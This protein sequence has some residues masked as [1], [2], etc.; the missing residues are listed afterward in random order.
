MAA[1]ITKDATNHVWNFIDTFTSNTYQVVFDTQNKFLDAKIKAS[2]TVTNGAITPTFDEAH[3]GL[4]SYFTNNGTASSYNI[5]IKPQATNTAGFIPLHNSSN[6]VNGQTTY[7]KI[8]TG[9]GTGDSANVVLYTTDGSKAGENISA[10]V[11]AVQ[12]SEP[13]VAGSYYLAFTGSGNSKINKD[14][15]LTSGTIL[16]PGSKTRYFSIQAAAITASCTNATATTTVSPGTVSI[17]KNGTTSVSGKTQILTTIDPTLATSDISKYFIAI[18]ASA[19]ANST[20]TTSSIT[21]TNTA[22]VST[23]GYAPTTLTGAGAISGTATAKTSKRDSGVYYIPVPTAGYSGNSASAEI[24]KTTTDNAS[25]DGINV[26]AILGERTNAEPTSGYYISLQASGSGSSKITTA[27]WLPADQTLTS[28]STT[29]ERF[30]PVTAAVIAVSKTGGS[31]TPT[32]TLSKSNSVTWS[33]SDT[34][35]VWLQATGNGSVSNLSIKANVSTAGYIPTG[36]VATANSLSISAAATPATDKKYI[37]GVTIASGKSFA[38][39]NS[40]TTT[41]TAG[42]SGSTTY[43]I[44]N[45]VAYPSS[46]TTAE[47]SKKIVDG[48]RWVTETVGA[49]SS[50]FATKYGKTIVK[51][52]AASSNHTISNTTYITTSGASSSSY[53]LYI[54]PRHTIGTA[55]YL[56]AASNVEGTKVYYKV[57]RTSVSQNNTTVNSTDSSG[58]PTDVTRGEASWGDGWVAGS[59]IIPATFKNAPTSGVTYIDISKTEEAPILTVLDNNG[60]GYLYINKGYVDNLKISLARLIPD[61]LDGN[62]INFAPANYILTGYAAFDASGVQITGTMQTYTGA[63][64]VTTP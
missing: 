45:V 51:Y 3:S 64:T 31:I 53:D 50:T 38:V 11:T 6:P 43:G 55:G 25:T 2:L 29:A 58:N 8:I 34:S 7:Y 42:I 23:A 59:N 35:G 26:G 47:A 14:G 33:T 36:D 15:W 22:S 17:T 57:K 4:L 39:A 12:D 52:G 46:G 1:S 56:A 49:G 5:Y 21:G 19:A 27:G 44:I 16:P 20:G 13:E 24:T 41:V 30:F 62:N 32:T 63:Y 60:G 37:T 48:G 40:G 28:A 61:T 10:I 54:T 9:G 18:K